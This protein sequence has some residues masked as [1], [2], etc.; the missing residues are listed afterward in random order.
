MATAFTP[1]NDGMNDE[2]LAVHSCDFT[3]FNMKILNRW[4]KVIFETN[5][6]YTGWDGTVDGELVP[7]GTYIYHLDFSWQV[8]SAPQSRQVTGHFSVIR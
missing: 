6:P 5:D 7:N 3:S 8:Y 4:G 1:N 2:Y